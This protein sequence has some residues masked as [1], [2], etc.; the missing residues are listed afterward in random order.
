MQTKLVITTLLV[1]SV[2][3]LAQEPERRTQT[4]PREYVRESVLAQRDFP[5][6]TGMMGDSKVRSLLAN[7]AALS[8][9]ATER[10][11]AAANASP[12]CK[13]DLACMTSALQ[14]SPQQIAQISALLRG[15]YERSEVL[16]QYVHKALEGN[17]EYSL[18]LSQR[19]ADLLVANWERSAR[20]INQAIA[21]YGDGAKPRYAEIDSMTYAADSR[22]YPNL[23]RILLDN[24]RL[25][26]EA[27]ASA[28]EQSLFFEPSLRFAV[29]LLQSNSRDEA[30]R[31][32]P[33]ETGQNR[34]A[35]MRAKAFD[36]KIYPYS[37]ILIPGAGSEVPNV[38]LS[39]WGKERLRLGVAAY[40]AGLAPFI[41]VS[42]GFVHPSQTP[43][44][45]AL[46]MKRYLMQVYALAE[47][48]ILVEP[49]A[50]HTTTNLRN[51]VREISD[52]GLPMDKPMLI[53]SDTAQSDSIAGEAFQ[54]RN[55]Q[56]LGYQPVRLGKRLS[57]TRQEALPSTQSLFRDPLDPLD[58]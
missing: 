30:G 46:E 1:F 12:T 38:S 14:L 19:G 13:E 16:R 36:P 34:E 25:P 4:T 20:A 51:A 11:Q 29:R 7:D 56:E 3:A 26:E 52:Y 55:L 31:Y 5:F 2:A 32:W 24:L 40:R 35:I 44:C 8:G 43:F 49:Y 22:T 47:S 9:I 41:M 42:G 57:S 45:E 54:K 58:P 33:L 23:I 15:T 50:R 37:V 10:W 21:T 17:S 39:P 6:L 27:P 18:D 28:D 48:A 53:V